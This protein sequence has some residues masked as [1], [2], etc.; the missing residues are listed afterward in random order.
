MPDCQVT[1]RLHNS[2]ARP[3]AVPARQARKEGRR[4]WTA[5]QSSGSRAI[6]SVPPA[7]TLC[8]TTYKCIWEQGTGR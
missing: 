1:H 8:S 6:A 2:C 5:H 7:D 4:L 3:L